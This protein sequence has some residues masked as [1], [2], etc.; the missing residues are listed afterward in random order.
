MHAKLES[1]TGRLEAERSRVALLWT[2][3]ALFLL[4][5]MNYVDR[6]LFAVAQESIKTDLH[7]SDFQLGL[8]GGPAFAILYTLSTF[9][10]ARLADRGNRVTIISLSFAAWSAMTAFCGIAAS[11]WQMLAGRA[12]VSIGEAGCTPAAHS[13]I[14]DAFPPA[15]RTSAMSIFVAAGPLGAL[16]AALGGG[17]LIQ[18]LGWRPVFLICGAIGI[19]FALLFRTTVREPARRS[20]HR[21]A[22]LMPTIRTLLAKRSFAMV[23]LACSIAGVASYSNHQY[24]VSFFIRAHGMSV[25][26]ASTLLG[27]VI[28][29]VGI[30][31][32]LV[33]GAVMDSGRRRFPNIRIWLPAA[34]LLWCGVANAI[35]F[36]IPLLWMAVPMFVIGSLGQHFYMPA[37]YTI[38]QDVAPPAMRAMASAITIAISSL[39]G[40]GLGPPAVGWLSDTLTATA[41]GQAGL[42]AADCVTMATNPACVAASAHG[43]RLS[44]SAGSC[45]YV[46]AGLLFALAGRW[47]R[48]DMASAMDSHSSA[49]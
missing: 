20:D 34:G 5:T 42:T 10:I 30:V 2:L 6:L 11:F 29:G 21:Q 7:L 8:I 38:G 41:M 9:P 18:A 14:S 13:L 47:A 16:V 31:M 35:A 12:A 39:F 23:A 27:L 37:T 15:R 4:N 28:G 1:G 36:Q 33:S 3:A 44:L 45:F 25:G 49:E 22:R 40:Y 17:W 19:V 48:Q 24:M 46:L 26:Q 32:T 43:L